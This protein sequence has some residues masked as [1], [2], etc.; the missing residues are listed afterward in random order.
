M[1]YRFTLH[2]Y[3]ENTIEYKNLLIAED[4]SYEENHINVV[5]GSTEE[6]QID[7]SPISYIDNLNT[8]M[9]VISEKDT[10]P[11]H[12]SFEALIHEKEVE[13]VEF[14]NFNVMIS[15]KIS[16]WKFFQTIL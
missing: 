3:K 15:K 2:V 9:L 16:A 12:I 7:A 8:P 14:L 1:I 5:F 10:Y 6:E 4:P 11:Y 13:N